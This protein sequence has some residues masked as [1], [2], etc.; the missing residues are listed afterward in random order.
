MKHKRDRSQEIRAAIGHWLRLFEK[1]ERHVGALVC[2]IALLVKRIER[3]TG[4]RWIDDAL[5]GDV[6]RKAIERLIFHFAPTP[7]KPVTVPSDLDGITGELITIAENLCP[8]PGLPDVPPNLFG[9]DWAPLA[10][11]VRDIGSGWERNRAA[12]QREAKP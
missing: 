6:V 2:L 8:Q 1:P 5:T 11:I 9:D 3:R 12:W 4:R 10:L 7:A